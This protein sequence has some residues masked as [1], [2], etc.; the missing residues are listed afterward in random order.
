[1]ASNEVSVGDRTVQLPW[2]VENVIGI[3]G[4]EI[5]VL[6]SWGQRYTDATLE[7]EDP[8]RN[9]VGSGSADDVWVVGRTDRAD[10]HEE[11][12]HTYVYTPWDRLVSTTNVGDFHELDPDTGAILDSWDAD[13]FKMDGTLVD[14]P[15]DVRSVQSHDEHI[16]VVTTDHLSVFTDDAE[17]VWRRAVHRKWSTWPQDDPFTVRAPSSG[18]GPGWDVT[19]DPQTGEVTQTKGK[20]VPEDFGDVEYL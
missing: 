15:G 2:S 12:Y 10:L 19:L 7:I 17:P 13:Q 4:G 3:N 5:Y 1:M 6:K 9:I 18:A 8:S 16:I 11:Y 14:F 20:G